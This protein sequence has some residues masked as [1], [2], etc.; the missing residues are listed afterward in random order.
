MT[1]EES[2][3]WGRY[4]VLEE[5]CAH[6]I[7]RIEVDPGARLSYQRHARRAEHWFVVSGTVEITLEGENRHLSPGDVA[8]IPCGAAHRAGN[9]GDVPAVFIEVQ[10]GDYFGEDDIERL[11]DDYAR[12]S[13]NL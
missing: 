6:K 1:V 13:W 8:D 7:K 10:T 3:P 12:A 4:V 5:S 9:P 2:R 11:E